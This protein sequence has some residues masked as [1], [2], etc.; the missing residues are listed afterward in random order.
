MVLNKYI[1]ESADYVPGIAGVQERGCRFLFAGLHPNHTARSSRFSFALI[2]LQMGARLGIG[3][4]NQQD[5]E[6]KSEPNW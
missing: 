5:E 2:E 6:I 4:I 1:V 3:K